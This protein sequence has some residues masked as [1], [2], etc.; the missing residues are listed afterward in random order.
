[1]AHQ[2]IPDILIYIFEQF[3]EPSTP[4]LGY[5]DLSACSLVCR[6]WQI[7]AQSVLFRHIFLAHSQQLASFLSVITQTFPPSSPINKH[8]NELARAVRRIRSAA[9]PPTAFSILRHCENLVEFQEI[10]SIPQ[11]GPLL[12]VQGFQRANNAHLQSLSVHIEDMNLLDV[13]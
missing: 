5:S 2:I 8:K 12:K 4:Y 9:D 10:C 3:L 1:M 7:F 13:L 11:H 6:Q